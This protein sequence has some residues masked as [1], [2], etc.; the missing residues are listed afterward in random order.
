MRFLNK[1]LN[2]RSP[3]LI[4]PTIA[5]QYAIDAE[6]FGF[7][8]LLT[9]VFGEVAKPYK[10][11]G[12]GIIPI[13]GVIG[14]GLS[15]LERMTG[16]SDLNIVSDQIDA[17]LADSEVQTLVFHIDSPGGVVGGVEEVARK[18]AN[19][20]K[21]TIAYTDGMMCSAAYWLGS[22]ADR[23]ISSPSADVGSIGVYMN[24]IDV[25]QAY[26]DMGVKAVVI[27][28]SATPYKAAGI[29]GTSLSTEQIAYFQNEV[30]AIYADFTSSVKAKR[31]M[32][33]EDAMKGQSMSGKIASS[34][35]LLTGLADSLSEILNASTPKNNGV[36]TAKK[37]SATA[38]QKKTS[39]IEDSVLELLTP[40]QKEMVDSYCDVEETFG[41][42]K[43]DSSPDGAHYSAVSPFAGSN[44]FCQNCVFY[45]GPRG[46]GL[47]EGDI[48][49]NGICKLWVIPGSLIKE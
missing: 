31:K 46:C 11:G 29:E 25:S 5:K 34:M 13:V 17:F 41:M 43:Q 47:V 23:V 10:V 3:M 39:E 6:K 20:S 16:A 12:Y 26:A 45:R 30:D 48:D 15:P 35:G 42:F 21:P 44:L 40:R 1:A 14:K 27:K 8:D 18:I 37:V 36:M 9:Q 33:S 19:S 22:S 38:I 28:S 2:G 24:L 7:T 49:P 32:A 4:D